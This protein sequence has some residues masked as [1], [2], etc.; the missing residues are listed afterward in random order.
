MYYKRNSLISTLSLFALL[1]YNAQVSGLKIPFSNSKDMKRDDSTVNVTLPDIGS[2]KTYVCPSKADLFRRQANGPQTITI[3]KD[4][5][6]TFLLEL[7]IIELQMVAAI[8]AL[9][10]GGGFETS[11]NMTVPSTTIH[12]ISD[13]PSTLPEPTSTLIDSTTTTTTI[14]RTTTL[15]KARSK[16]SDVAAASTAI[17]LIPAVAPTPEPVAA[18][19]TTISDASDSA[20]NLGSTT[21]SGTIIGGQQPASST[22]IPIQ[23][24]KN[25]TTAYTFDAESSSNV[26]VYFGQSPATG[27]S[28]LES[29]CADPNIDI[30]I[31]AFITSPRDGGTYPAI[32]FG[33]ACTGQTNIM[34]TSAP[35][36]LS[37]PGLASSIASC[38]NTHGKRVFLS[39]GGST[40]QISFTSDADGS[41]FADVLWRLFGPPGQVDIM[42]RPFGNV[43]IDG[44]DVGKLGPSP[45]LP[46]KRKS[47]A[48]T[49]KTTKTTT[50]LASP[51]SPPPSA[52][53]FPQPQNHTTSPAHPNVHSQMPQTPPL[54]SYSAISS[55]CNSTTIPHAR[56]GPA[57]SRIA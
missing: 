57:G 2:I 3:P 44:F 15:V 11:S 52:P 9:L 29:Q 50:Q 24:L 1:P 35:G 10:A 39:M 49:S 55:G 46:P 41:A 23:H 36:L 6:E 25:N 37:C 48:N 8:D 54:C 28:S 14:S 4:Q 7:K 40:G 22:P 51:P 27:T 53:T 31:L 17:P 26:A 42:L 21:A 12:L 38:Q 34:K 32:N 30:V 16:A 33:G 45:Y 56:S 19:S 13:T 5:V 47:Y 20:I 43:Q 18:A